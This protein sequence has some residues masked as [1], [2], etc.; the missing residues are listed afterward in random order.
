MN[1]VFHDVFNVCFIFKRPSEGDKTP[2]FSSQRGL[3]KMGKR[4]SSFI[5]GEDIKLK[6]F[7][8]L[9]SYDNTQPLQFAFDAAILCA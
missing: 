1:G 4:K 3:S 6:T 5:K 2:H 7:D 9:T 8:H